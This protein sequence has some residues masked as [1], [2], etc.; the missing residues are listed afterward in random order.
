MSAASTTGATGTTDALST[1]RSV[2]A[3]ARNAHPIDAKSDPFGLHAQ[4]ALQTELLARRLEFLAAVDELASAGAD[5]DDL[6]NAKRH[7]YMSDPINGHA[8][9]EHAA[10][11]L[12]QKR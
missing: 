9:L 2:A 5:S 12:A 6:L 11:R 7:L 4:A 1:W 8:Y 10:S 3:A